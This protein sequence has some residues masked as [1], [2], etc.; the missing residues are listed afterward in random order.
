MRKTQKNSYGLSPLNMK[1]THTHEIKKIKNK[2]K[3]NF[4]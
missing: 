3:K 1:R 2:K 4:R